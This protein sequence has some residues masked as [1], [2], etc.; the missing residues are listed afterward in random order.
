MNDQFHHIYVLL[1]CINQNNWRFSLQLDEEVAQAHLSHLGVKLTKLTD[2]QAS[3]LGL[4]KDGPFK[5]DHYR[6]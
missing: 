3:Y 1:N 6:Y 4:N 2:D 5:P